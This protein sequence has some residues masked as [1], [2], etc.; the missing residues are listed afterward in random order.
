MLRIQTMLNRV[1]KKIRHMLGGGRTPPIHKRVVSLEPEGA[2]RGRVLLSY[3]IEPFLNGGKHIDNKHTH[4][5][6]S[7]QIAQT[8][9]KHRYA[10]DVISYLNRAFKPEK[11]YD[12]FFSART[13]LERISR[14]LN[15]DCVKVAHLDT[16][17]WVFNNRA[18]YERM[19]YLLERRGVVVAGGKCVEENWAIEAADLG[20]VLGNRFTM[21]TY[22]YSGKPIHRIPISAPCTYAWDTEKNF[23]AC[24]RNFIWFGSSGFVHKGLDIVLDAFAEMPEYTLYVCGPIDQEAR[25]VEA[26]HQELYETENIKTIGW[27]DVESEEFMAVA[28]QCAALVYPTCAE[29]GG[30]SVITC[31]HAGLI[32]V[33]SHEASVDIDKQCGMVLEGCKVEDIRRAVASLASRNAQELE[34]MARAAWKMARERHTRERFAAE[35][36]RFVTGRLL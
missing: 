35:F 27:V 15:R 22:A 20:T 2:V 7:Y 11:P 1:R 3:I 29:G 31:M 33:V 24:R 23:E 10:V 17:H 19:A 12:Y 21:D 34:E 14:H 4:Y 5:W 6:E 8:F 25:F 13:N 32:P 36:E 16:A 28:R 18:A 9:L 26:Y 30:G